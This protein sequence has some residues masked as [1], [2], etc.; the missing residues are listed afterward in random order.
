MAAV[1]ATEL[2]KTSGQLGAPAS[3][4]PC[5]EAGGA[6]EGPIRCG[7]LWGGRSEAGRAASCPAP[8]GVAVALGTPGVPEEAEEEAGHACACVA[9]VLSCACAEVVEAADPED[10]GSFPLDRLDLAGRACLD[11]ATC[12]P[13]LSSWVRIRS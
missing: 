2:V 3:A 12:D 8:W 7:S 10:P 6:E 11:T 5:L 4:G 9:E 13:C 1:N